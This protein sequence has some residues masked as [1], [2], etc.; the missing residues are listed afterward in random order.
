[1]L[2]REREKRKNC[3]KKRPKRRKMMK[4][5]ELQMQIMEWR[6]VNAVTGKNAVWIVLNR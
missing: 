3:I 5:L 4:C 1:M 6:W 2:R